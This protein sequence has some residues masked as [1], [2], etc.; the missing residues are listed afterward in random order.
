MRDYNIDSSDYNKLVSH[1]YKSIKND[2]ETIIIYEKIIN[3]LKDYNGRVLNVRIEKFIKLD[4]YTVS[5]SKRYNYHMVYIAKGFKRYE[6]QLSCCSYEKYLKFDINYLIDVLKYLKIKYE[7][8][9]KEIDNISLY[10]CKFNTYLKLLD[11]AKKDLYKL[12]NW[13]GFSRFN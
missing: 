8:D 9:L 7:K 3:I 11:E 10:V 6:I 1:V 2:E 13:N 5:Y 4:G 12:P